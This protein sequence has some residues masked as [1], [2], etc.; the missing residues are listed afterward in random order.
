MVASSFWITISTLSTLIEPAWLHTYVHKRLCNS[1][2]IHWAIAYLWNT[3]NYTKSSQKGKR[4]MAP[5]LPTTSKQSAVEGGYYHP[6]DPTRCISDAP[7]SHHHDQWMH[8]HQ[9]AHKH[10]IQLKATLSATKY[11]HNIKENEIHFRTLPKP[12]YPSLFWPLSWS[13]SSSFLL[14]ASSWSEEGGCAGNMLNYPSM[15]WFQAVSWHV[16][17]ASMFF[18]ILAAML[19]SLWS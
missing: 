13:H 3:R 17:Q 7:H 5:W 8:H 11:I 10:W 12:P 2:G 19:I 9:K 16:F 4:S 6:S 18:V 1:W 14:P 15:I